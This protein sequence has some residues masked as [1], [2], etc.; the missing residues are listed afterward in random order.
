MHRESFLIYMEFPNCC[1]PSCLFSRWLIPVSIPCVSVRPWVGMPHLPLLSNTGR[2]SGVQVIPLFPSQAL[3]R[4]IL[5]SAKLDGAIFMCRRRPCTSPVASDIA[6]VYG[7]LHT[8]VTSMS[9][10]VWVLQRTRATLWRPASCHR[11]IGISQGWHP[12]E[13]WGNHAQLLSL[14]GMHWGTSRGKGDGWSA[15]DGNHSISSAI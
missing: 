15:A 7:D 3:L 1:S 4:C 13:R 2:G 14:D 6:R 5:L 10:E 12:T 11:N 9:C 8:R